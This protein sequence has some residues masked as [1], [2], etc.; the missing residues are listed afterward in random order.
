MRRLP[1]H[2]AGPGQL[3]QGCRCCCQVEH[4]LPAVACRLRQR[5][6]PPHPCWYRHRSGALPRTRHGPA[7]ETLVSNTLTGDA[8]P[9]VVL[10]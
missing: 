3:Q 4:H 10:H 5:Q 1:C 8:L 7:E 6:A 9:A 2:S